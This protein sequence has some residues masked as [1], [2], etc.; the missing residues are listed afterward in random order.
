M[1]YLNLSILVKWKGN[2]VWRNALA[3]DVRATNTADLS[4]ELQ[5]IFFMGMAVWSFS[6]S[7]Q[8]WVYRKNGFC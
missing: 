3:K 8:G 4:V 6:E 7:E 1:A 5:V 2:E